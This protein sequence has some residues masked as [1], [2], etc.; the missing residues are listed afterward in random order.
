MKTPTDV[1]NTLQIAL[2]HVEDLKIYKSVT[3][4]IEPL[5]HV[6]DKRPEDVFQRSVQVLAIL[7]DIST[8]TKSGEV[9]LPTT[10]DLIKPRDIYQSAIKVVRVLES[11]K[12]RL[13]VAAQVEPSKAAVRISP[14]H[15][16]RE[17]DRLDRELKLLHHAFC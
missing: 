9:E 1:Y 8:S 10:P 5:E 13:G 3:E 2:A 12:R 6:T 4:Y 17:I 16:Y 14:S 11:I 15:V 7:K